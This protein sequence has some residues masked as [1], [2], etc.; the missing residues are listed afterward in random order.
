MNSLTWPKVIGA[1]LTPVV[2]FAILVAISGGCSGHLQV[3]S[4]PEDVIKR[5]VD[6][7]NEHTTD[8]QIQARIANALDRIEHQLKRIADKKP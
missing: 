6:H 8:R 3:A 2:G 5:V 1:V 7:P 4:G